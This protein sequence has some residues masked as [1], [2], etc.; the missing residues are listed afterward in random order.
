V[1]E[2]RVSTLKDRVLGTGDGV[3]VHCEFDD[4]DF[5]PRFT[6]GVCP[7]CGWRPEG[8][9]EQAPLIERMDWFMVML[10]VVV[11]AS[12]VM[13]ILVIHAYVQA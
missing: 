7:L 9:V 10:V 12:I 11:I 1:A 3:R 5:S 13:G 8:I 2:G 6:D 4:W